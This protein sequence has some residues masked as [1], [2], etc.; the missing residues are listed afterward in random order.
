MMNDTERKDKDRKFFDT[1]L[2]KRRE[3]EIICR[4][5]WP[6]RRKDNEISVIIAKNPVMVFRVKGLNHPPFEHVYI[7]DLQ[8]GSFER[9]VPQ[10][11]EKRNHQYQ[12]GYWTTLD[13]S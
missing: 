7:V 9:Y 5:I 12:N 8:E 13:E 6:G 1:L 3:L 10:G 4:D 2:E 11:E